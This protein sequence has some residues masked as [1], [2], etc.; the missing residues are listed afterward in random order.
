MH[1]NSYQI[2]DL[3]LEIGSAKQILAGQPEKLQ[4]LDSMHAN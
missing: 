2:K 3:I 1:N 4:Q